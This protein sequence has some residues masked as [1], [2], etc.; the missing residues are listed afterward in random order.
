MTSAH[1]FTVE[2]NG[3]VY[4]EVLEVT[5]TSSWKAWKSRPPLNPPL[6][7]VYRIFVWFVLRRYRSVSLTLIILDLSASNLEMRR[8][9][10]LFLALFLFGGVEARYYLILDAGSSGTR[11]VAV[12]WLSGSGWNASYNPPLHFC[13]GGLSKFET[14]ADPDL[15][16][17]ALSAYFEPFISNATQTIPAEAH[18]DT[19]IHVRGTGGMRDMPPQVGDHIMAATLRLLLKS[20][21][22]PFPV[23][24]EHVQ[25]ISGNEEGVVANWHTVYLRLIFRA[26]CLAHCERSFDCS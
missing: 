23:A 5:L 11:A 7:T 2:A 19:P 9:V 8:L 22:S 12:Q 16:L 1:H 17:N 10:V 14:V 18:N 13:K 25:I 15:L 4:V 24:K 6:K 20:S 21:F 3:R 26:S